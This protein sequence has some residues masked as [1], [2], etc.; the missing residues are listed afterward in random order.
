MGNPS[1]NQCNPPCPAYLCAEFSKV[2]MCQLAERD[3]DE[4]TRCE[5]GVF[6]DERCEDC[7]YVPDLPCGADL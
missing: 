4:E 3:A 5:H 1:E 2:D 7:E 6:G